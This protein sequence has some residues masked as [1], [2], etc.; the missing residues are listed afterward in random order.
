MEETKGAAD[1]LAGMDNTGMYSLQVA[2][3][4]GKALE[5]PPAEKK[6]LAIALAL[7]EKGRGSLKVSEFSKALVF[8]L[9]AD[10]VYK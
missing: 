7:H 10:S 6:A 2:D 1:Y 3:Q 9:E 8:L 4:S 5:L